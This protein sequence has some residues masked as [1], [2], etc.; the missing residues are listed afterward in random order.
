MMSI[1]GVL[2]PE[3]L[4]A[5]MRASRVSMPRK[6]PAPSTTGNSCC[7]VRN[8]KAAASST[9]ESGLSDWNDVIM[10]CEAR[11]PRVYSRAWT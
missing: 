11:Y 2:P 6:L 10:A 9:V 8:S 7:V 3:S 4:S 1:T 5:A